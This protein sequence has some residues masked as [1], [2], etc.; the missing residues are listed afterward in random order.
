SINIKVAMLESVHSDYNTFI[1][2]PLLLS[3]AFIITHPIVSVII[4]WWQERL[5]DIKRRI[6][7]SIENGAVIPME[8]YRKLESQTSEKLTKNNEMT[9]GYENKIEKLALRNRDVLL[10][11]KEYRQDNQQLRKKISEL[12]FINTDNMKFKEDISQYRT[13]ID[14]L[15][16]ELKKLSSINDTNEET[17]NMLTKQF[18]FINNYLERKGFELNHKKIM[19][20]I[21]HLAEHSIGRLTYEIKKLGLIP[22]LDGDSKSILLTAPFYIETDHIEK[23]AEKYCS[24]LSVSPS[25]NN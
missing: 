24:E 13:T 21:S 3:L 1:L 20:D 17:A 16:S 19:I 23:L 5:R 6:K 2:K 11:M 15:K 4:F 22:I 7:L 10:K 14:N 25:E 8:E 9:L 18:E 12:D